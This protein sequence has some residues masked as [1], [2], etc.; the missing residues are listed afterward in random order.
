MQILFKYHIDST[1]FLVGIIKL[2]IFYS[3]LYFHKIN[4]FHKNF[5]KIRIFVQF[6]KYTYIA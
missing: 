5:V 6:T 4:N 1:Q 2:V 3:L